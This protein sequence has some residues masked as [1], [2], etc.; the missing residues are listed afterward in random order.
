[1]ITDFNVI[2][3]ILHLRGHFFFEMIYEEKFSKKSKKKAKVIDDKKIYD[4]LF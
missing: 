3:E 2:V 4:I 1:M